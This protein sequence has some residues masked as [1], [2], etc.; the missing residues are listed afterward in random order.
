MRLAKK[1]ISLGKT[2]LPELNDPHVTQELNL[3]LE[4]SSVANHERATFYEQ[5]E[6]KSPQVSEVGED[7]PRPLCHFLMG[8]FHQRRIPALLASFERILKLG[9]QP[10]LSEFAVLTQELL[11]R[12]WP[13]SRTEL[14]IVRM[15]H[16]DPTA[17]AIRIA[18]A[19]GYHRQTVA[20]YIKRLYFAMKISSYPLVNY[21]ALGLRRL[22]IWFRGTPEV[23]TSP[24][25]YSRLAL[26][27]NDERRLVD[28]WS[29]PVGAESLL[30]DYYQRLGQ[31]HGIHD[32]SVRE[33]L[34]F[35]KNLSLSTYE[36]SKGWESDPGVVKLLYERALEGQ[37]LFLP[38][39]LEVMVYGTSQTPVLDGIDIAII[40]SLWKDYLLGQTREAAAI[41]LNISR[42][43]FSRRLQQLEINNVI[44]PSLWLKTENMVQTALSIPVSEA[45]VVNALMRLPVVYFYLNE[46]KESEDLQWFVV[47]KSTPAVADILAKSSED[48]K[49]GLQAFNVQNIEKR[50]GKRIFQAYDKK[51]NSWNL[52]SLLNNAEISA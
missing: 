12:P 41:R 1:Q 3:L 50:S 45:Q 52:E 32:L 35:G 15:L 5:W 38:Q 36:E 43:S 42:S 11:K 46:A 27:G 17:S 6:T 39:P 30:L 40:E 8:V 49:I 26:T 4:M 14:E 24:Y 23:P 20:S 47:V 21:H 33:L 31:T 29:V 10:S 34:S 44:R 28:T 19:T 48:N 51:T 13:L 16:E 22:Q 37:A 9:L 18:Q 2:L 25:F 7:H